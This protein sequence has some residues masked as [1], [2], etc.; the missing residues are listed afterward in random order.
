MGEGEELAC[1][2][3]WKMNGS[4][5]KSSQRQTNVC[6][7]VC[8]CARWDDIMVSDCQGVLEVETWTLGKC[9]PS[10]ARWGD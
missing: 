5:R 7:H 9:K 4:Q 6:V 10:E 2:K 3:E 1:T 8:V